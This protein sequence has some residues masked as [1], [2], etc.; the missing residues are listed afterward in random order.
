MM[1]SNDRGTDKVRFSIGACG[2][3][4]ARERG[5]FRSHQYRIEGRWAYKTRGLEGLS[6]SH[7]IATVLE[8][9]QT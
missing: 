6:V 7:W 2:S 9:E 5:K 8:W 4:R 3:G 1:S